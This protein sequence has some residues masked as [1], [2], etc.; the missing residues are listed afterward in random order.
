VDSAAAAKASF[1][2]GSPEV[3][4]AMTLGA[5]LSSTVIPARRPLR[6]RAEGSRRNAFLAHLADFWSY[7]TV[8]LAKFRVFEAKKQI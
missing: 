8:F 7:P 4:A 3:L 6:L 2:R 5:T 1:R